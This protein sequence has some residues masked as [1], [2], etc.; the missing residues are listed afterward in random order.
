LN[1]GWIDYFSP[2]LY[3]PINR[4]TQ[5]FPVLLGW[6]TSE[7]TL[8]RHLWPGISLG[9]DTSAK[10]VN[11]IMGQIMISRG[12]L[13]E[14]KGVVHWSIGSLTKNPN[15][16]NALLKGPYL[17]QALVPSSPWLDNQPPVPPAVK[18]NKAQNAVSISWTH[19][20]EQDV[21]RWIV[22]TLHG[23]NW[24][25]T[26]LNKHERNFSL[27]AQQNLLA[28]IC[29]TAVDRSGNE[30]EPRALVLE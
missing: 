16:A 6:W 24:R 4:I 12:M 17:Q 29:V 1:K 3:W 19:A 25:Y 2:Q 27:S 21:F 10:N 23:N 26:I 30:S 5:S 22:Y 9:T 8:K 13:P 18:I 28:K 11:E 15:M 20:D 14:S 7:N